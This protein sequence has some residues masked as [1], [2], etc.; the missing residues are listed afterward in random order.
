M[1]QTSIITLLSIWL[2]TSPCQAQ[3]WEPLLFQLYDTEEIEEQ[4]WEDLY[5]TLADLAQ[6]PIN[7]NNVTT[8][9]LRR[10]PFLTDSE[11][12]DIEEYLYRYGPFT[13]L[14]EL[15][16]IPSISYLKRKLLT[17]FLVPGASL[18]H[19]DKLKTKD[20]LRYGKHQILLSGKIP[21]YEREGDRKGYMG[22]PYKHQSR[23][24]FQYSDHIKAGLVGAQDAGEPFFAGKNR[25]GYDHYASYL[26][27]NKIG[28]M[29][30]LIIGNYK[31]NIGSG[32][33]INNGM[34]FGKST[35]LSGLDIHRSAIR[36]HASSSAAGYLQGTA[37]TL[38]LSSQT[39]L[40]V[41][42]S[43][44]HR[45][46]TLD[47][48]SKEIHTILSSGYHR[49]QT[50]MSKKGNIKEQV[51]GVHGVCHYSHG[52]I[53]LAGLYT[54]LSKPFLRDTNNIYRRYY[55][56]GKQFFHVTAEYQYLNRRFAMTGETAVSQTG[57]MA[58]LN[59]I[60][61]SLSHSC[62]ITMLQRFY[63]K[64][65]NALLSNAFSE[66]G[67][68]QNESG[69]YIGL[70]YHPSRQ[71][72]ISY[73]TDYAYFP[74]PRYQVSAASHTWDHQLSANYSCGNWSFQMRY[75]VKQKEK[76]DENHELKEVYEQKGRVCALYQQ[77]SWSNQT[78]IQISHVKD[79]DT[80]EGFLI[81]NHTL[82]QP[83]SRWRLFLQF[84]YFH[85]DD[86]Q[87]RLYQY[88]QGP[89]YG[90]S[91]IMCAGRGIRYSVLLR[92]EP[93][94]RWM[95]CAKHG[96]TNY[97]DRDTIGSGYQLIHHSSVT[98]LE[99]QLRIKW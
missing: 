36:P 30:S 23:Y 94:K 44:Q 84:T 82:I 60:N 88:E 37:I 59:K 68:V 81:S 85:T 50:E 16:M 63:G 25:L 56:Q 99:V 24:Q 7:I 21:L 22:Y 15:A 38:Q 78:N 98:D 75:R 19:S 11:I 48:Q 67:R 3:S 12:E 64:K 4:H 74:W 80:H 20:I 47:K 73:Y 51:A 40:D 9:Q 54:R 55:P 87:S 69:V 89:L 1:K 95:I 86:Y 13:S 97:F 34:S 5:E 93:S 10:I 39:S 57:A 29:L 27:I 53:G 2:Y 52:Y 45:D 96:T 62:D 31:V 70:Q 41:F 58:T 76:D 46:A 90:S 92:Y 91:F 43:S 61:C 18:K 42:L 8:E 66:S 26:Q 79:N 33:V 77:H 32:L 35:L 14:G 49:T 28:P 6:H 65:Y 83:C 17:F 72:S 71:V